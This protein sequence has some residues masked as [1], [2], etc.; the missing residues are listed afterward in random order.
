MLLAVLMTAK[1]LLFKLGEFPGEILMK[2]H[3]KRKHIQ[4]AGK[5][6]FFSTDCS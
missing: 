5:L 1:L 2:Q 6:D 4:F 3:P